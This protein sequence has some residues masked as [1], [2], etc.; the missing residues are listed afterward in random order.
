MFSF[1]ILQAFYETY[2]RVTPDDTSVSFLEAIIYI[3]QEVSFLFLLR[4]SSRKEYCFPVPMLGAS[5]QLS[6][7]RQNAFLYRVHRFP[8]AAAPIR[9]ARGESRT[10]NPLGTR[11]ISTLSTRGTDRR[12]AAERTRFSLKAARKERRG[13]RVRQSFQILL[14]PFF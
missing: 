6:Q 7:K 4:A 13:G 11:T 10:L 5:R 1:K 8:S 14:S 2:A 3:F 12:G 9:S